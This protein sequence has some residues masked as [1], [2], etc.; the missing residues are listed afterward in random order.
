[1]IHEESTPRQ[2]RHVKTASNP[3]DIS[4]R[5]VK[6]ADLEKMNLWLH[7]PEFLWKEEKC[8]PEQPSQLPELSEEDNECRKNTTRVNAIVLDKM[9]EP[10]LSRYS[11]W[12]RLRKGIAWLVRFKKYLIGC[13]CKDLSSVPKGPLSVVEVL[14]AESDIL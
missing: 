3:A 12:D 4:S 7:G 11:S 2:W 9:F 13:A 6:G 1:M 10:L 5:G 8:W 14:A